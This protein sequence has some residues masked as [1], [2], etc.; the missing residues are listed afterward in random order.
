MQTCYETWCNYY[1][2]TQGGRQQVAEVTEKRLG[3]CTGIEERII[4]FT[5]PFHCLTVRGYYNTI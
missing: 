5:S 1:S 4:T 3:L 2:Q